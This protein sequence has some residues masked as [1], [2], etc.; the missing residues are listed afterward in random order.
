MTQTAAKSSGNVLAN[1]APRVANSINMLQR[2]KTGL[3]PTA[4]DNGAQMNVPRP[5]QNVGAETRVSMLNG[6]VS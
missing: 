1:P 2:I 4:K 5:M 3:R 6:L